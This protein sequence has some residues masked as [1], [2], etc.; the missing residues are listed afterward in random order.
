MY[1]RAM[2]ILAIIACL[3]V[4]SEFIGVLQPFLRASTFADVSNARLASLTE[5][6]QTLEQLI[7]AADREMYRAKRAGKNR[8]S[9]SGNPRELWV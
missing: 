4:L 5:D 8:I 1:Q 9:V 3:I 6:T 2:Q 7:E